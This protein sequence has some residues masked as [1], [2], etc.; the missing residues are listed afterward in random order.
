V[1]VDELV[2][3]NDAAFEARVQALASA[4]AAETNTAQPD[5]AL[6]D[7]LRQQIVDM[8]TIQDNMHHFML[9]AAAATLFLPHYLP[10][11]SAAV[12]GND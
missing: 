10:Y 3:D 12:S 7:C 2:R 1:R 4:V 11:S 5:F 6:I 9:G 8:R